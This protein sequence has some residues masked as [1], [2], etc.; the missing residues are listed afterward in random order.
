LAFLG[1]LIIAARER[2][3][4]YSTTAIRLGVKIKGVWL[5]FGL[6]LLC[7]IDTYILNSQIGFAIS[8]SMFSVLGSMA[9]AMMY[10]YFADGGG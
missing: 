4:Q 7:V 1:I 9:Y 10:K 2:M 3:T 6:F 8:L 5:A